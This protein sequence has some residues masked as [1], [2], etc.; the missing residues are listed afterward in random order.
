[1]D[2]FAAFALEGPPIPAYGSAMDTGADKTSLGWL[3]EALERSEA[4]I[5]AGQTV[6]IEP[7][8]DRLRASIARMQA[9]RSKAGQEMARKV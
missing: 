5:S 4:Q 9:V 7:V 2:K 3:V 8:L 6:S 1:V